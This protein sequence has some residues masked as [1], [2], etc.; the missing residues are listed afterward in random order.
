[1]S[2]KIAEGLSVAETAPLVVEPMGDLP[3]VELPATIEER[4]CTKARVDGYYRVERNFRFNTS[5]V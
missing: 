4:I 1:V 2:Y 3:Y 5:T